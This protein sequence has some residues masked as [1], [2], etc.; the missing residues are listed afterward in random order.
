[1]LNAV[2][3]QSLLTQSKESARVAMGP[4]QDYA[5]K[6]RDRVQKMGIALADSDRLRTAEATVALLAAVSHATP[7][8]LVEKLAVAAV[9]TSEQAMG[10]CVGKAAGLGG[11][12]DAASWDLLEAVAQLGD[13]RKEAAQHMVDSVAQAQSQATR[14]LTQQPAQPVPAPVPGPVPVPLPVPLPVPDPVAVGTTPVAGGK[15]WRVLKRET[16]EN[17]DLSAVK[18]LVEDLNS[19]LTPER[20]IRVSVSWVIEEEDQQK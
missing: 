3:L 12:L 9:A 8:S 14:L 16:K 17:L 2:N 10:E 13:A 19:E 20:Q 15:K 6:L 7:D 1:L 5:K 4:C 18:G 11:A